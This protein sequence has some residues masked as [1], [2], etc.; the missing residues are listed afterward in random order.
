VAPV[1]AL[2]VLTQNRNGYPRGNTISTYLDVHNVGNQPVNY[3][4]L[5]VRYWFS[6]EGAASLSYAYDWAQVGASNV[7]GQLGQQGTNMYFE[8]SFDPSLGQLAPLSSTGDIH[9]RLNKTDWSTFVEDNDW[10]YRAPWE[11]V[12]ND[13]VTA[14]YQGKLVYGTEPGTPATA[15]RSTAAAPALATTAAAAGQASL[16]EAYPNPVVSATTVRFRAAQAGR[17]LVQVYNPLGQLVVTLY[18]EAVEDG[19]TY[20]LPFATQSLANGLYE[21][22]LMLGTNTLTKRLEISH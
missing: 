19:C 6:P 11:Y 17:A 15:A 1:L 13:H 12:S 7:R 18:D 10:S 14:Y 21:C 2:E 22:R 5:T 8:T 9:Y 16:L 3:A 4:D 20:E